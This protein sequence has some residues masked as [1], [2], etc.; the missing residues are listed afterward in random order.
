MQIFLQSDLDVS[1]ILRVVFSWVLFY[2]SGS[3]G[4][5]TAH[6]Q[7]LF[8]ANH[9]QPFH[10]EVT[11]VRNILFV[12]LVSAGFALVCSMP[13]A[14]SQAEEKK[15]AAEKGEKE[16]EVRA[17][18]EE[19]QKLL[20]ARFDLVEKQLKFEKKLFGE[21]GGKVRDEVIPTSEKYL[22]AALEL[23]ADRPAE[24]I[25]LLK[26]L[27]EYMKQIE[28]NLEK[29]YEEN[30]RW[31]SGYTPDPFREMRFAIEIEILR[32]KREQISKKSK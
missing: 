17:L 2:K 24:R 29:A 20:K 15:A 31:I 28:T 26:P 10:Y 7:T 9:I 21:I 3:W 19:I 30:N 27:A 13:A 16:K 22:R 14:L 32:A 5:E 1:N 12:F 4:E 23:T 6:N 18:D 11:V 8:V 25:A